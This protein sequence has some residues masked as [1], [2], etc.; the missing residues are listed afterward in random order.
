MFNYFGGQDSV[1][2]HRG[3]VH[4]EPLLIFK[5]LECFFH[6]HQTRL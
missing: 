4:A 5:V 3:L 6:H 2:P 1:Q